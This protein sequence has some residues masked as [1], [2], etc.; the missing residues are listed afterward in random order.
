MALSQDSPIT[1]EAVVAHTL[2]PQAELIAE[3]QL[4]VV[5]ASREDQQD[6]KITSLSFYTKIGIKR[7]DTFFNE[8]PRTNVMSPSIIE[9]KVS[10]CRLIFPS[11][12]GQ[13]SWLS[14]LTV[15][16]ESMLHRHISTFQWLMFPS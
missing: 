14:S 11:A 3:D 1:R 7:S 5:V 2:G 10:I 9:S 4:S 12:Q 15:A 6:Q 16:H 13:I 8:F